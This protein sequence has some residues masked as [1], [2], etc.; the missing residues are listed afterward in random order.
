MKVTVDHWNN[1]IINVTTGAELYNTGHGGFYQEY[2]FASY[3]TEILAAFL[4]PAQL[5]KYA[6]SGFYTLTLS[7]RQEKK[8][9]AA[10]DRR[11]QI[12]AK[13]RPAH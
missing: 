3:F 10:I 2:A 8:L 6:D 13:F 1:T 12:E 4:T 9:I 11:K 5:Y 7:K